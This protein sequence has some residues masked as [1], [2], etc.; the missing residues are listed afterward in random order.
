MFKYIG[1]WVLAALVASVT[2]A[3][4]DNI[5]VT[6]HLEVAVTGNRN[7]V[8]CSTLQIAWDDMKNNIIGEDIRL[9]KPLDL[10]RRLN[11]GTGARADLPEANYLALA[12][13]NSN[14]TVREINRAL[15]MKFGTRVSSRPSNSSGRSRNSRI[16]T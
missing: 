14:E 6:P 1:I 13:A 15:E 11:E 4:S 10:V 7:I 3:A 2:A 8:Y 5:L 12:G 16:R 9:E